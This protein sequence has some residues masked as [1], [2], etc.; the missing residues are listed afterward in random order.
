MKT[1]WM[2]LALLTGVLCFVLMTFIIIQ[3]IEPDTDALTQRFEG[4]LYH[5]V[6]Y[7]AQDVWVLTF[8]DGRIIKVSQQPREGWLL[9][10]LYGITV[11][12]N[13]IGI[14]L[15]KE[16]QNEKSQEDQEGLHP[17]KAF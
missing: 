13:G 5:V 7:A 1:L 3:D 17:G 9:A 15:V 6:Y 14:R 2:I 12:P 11:T 8:A 16:L 10:R 4:T